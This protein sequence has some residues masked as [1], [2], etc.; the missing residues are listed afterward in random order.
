AV[1]DITGAAE[2]LETIVDLT[3]YLPDGVILAEEDFKGRVNVT[4]VVEP[5]VERVASIS[6]D[7]I[8]IVNVPEGFNV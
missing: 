7:R 4:V 5:V 3:D 8:Q 2:S 1:L 6:P